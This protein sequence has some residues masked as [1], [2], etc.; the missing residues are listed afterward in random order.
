MKKLFPFLTLL[1]VIIALAGCAQ[2]RKLPPTI[3]GVKDVT[4]NRGEKF[5]P[6]DGVIITDD[7]DST[8]E[9]MKKV[10]IIG[11][12]DVDSPGTYELTIRVVDSDGLVAEVKFTLTVVDPTSDNKPPVIVGLD[13]YGFQ[14]FIIGG[15][16]DPK[17]FNPLKGIYGQD[18]EDGVL[19]PII[20][21]DGG[22]DLTK[23]GVYIVT[24]QVKDSEGYVATGTITVSVEPLRVL[25]ELPEDKNIKVVFWHAFGDELDQ[26]LKEYAEEFKKEYPN[27]TIEIAKQGGY[28][29]LLSKVSSAIL[30][31]I[32]PTMIVGYP[33]HITNYLASN[34]VEPLDQYVN[35]PKYGIELDDFIDSYMRENRAYDN[36]GTLY[37]LPFNKSSEA[38]IYN[39]TFFD[40]HSLVMPE[41]PTWDDIVNLSKKIREIKQGEDEFAIAYDSAANSFITLT[42]QWGGE[43]TGVDNNRRGIIKFDNPQTKEM[44]AF[45]RDLY[46]KNYFT[47]PQEWEQDYASDPFKNEKV[48]MTIGS[49]AGVRHNIPENGKFELG[50]VPI[51]QRSDDTKAVIQQGTNLSILKN[52]SPEE[53]LAAWLFIRYL[54]STEITTD[55]AIKTGYLPV[56]ESAYTSERYQN[57]LNLTGEFEVPDKPDKELTQEQV[58]WKYL[59][60]TAKAAYAQRNYMFVDQPFIRSAK[61]RQ[62]VDQLMIEVIVG[63]VGIDEAIRKALNELSGDPNIIIP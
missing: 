62:T 48:F 23:E 41:N 35:H 13:L 56:R 59:S 14:T 34:A 47:L 26:Y 43:Y 37:G 15:S 40:Q 38:L 24:I 12:Y 51:P 20:V 7:K 57:F 32:E 49:T 55:W 63:G 31:G 22:L 1:V 54:T 11:T 60:M 5:D 2:K 44:L 36:R 30:A 28:N 9:L 25:E 39:K 42:R 45:F 10:E 50:I 29:D 21:D 58:R 33:D 8:E 6:L 46:N 18:P 53:K 52:N 3:E 16:V 27:V 19:E 17:D 4:I 61:V